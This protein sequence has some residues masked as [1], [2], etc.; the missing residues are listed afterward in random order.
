[1]GYRCTGIFL[2]V[3]FTGYRVHTSRLF[4]VLCRIYHGVSVYRYSFSGYYLCCVHILGI[5]VVPHVAVY[6]TGG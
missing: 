3:I 4:G 6:R 1:M 5:S 2:A